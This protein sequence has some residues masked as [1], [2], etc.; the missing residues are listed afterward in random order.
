[1][2]KLIVD[3]SQL[4]NTK[5]ESYSHSNSI[6]N[7]LSSFTLT[8]FNHINTQP[9]IITIILYNKGV[10]LWIDYGTLPVFF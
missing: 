1:M 6:V 3:K 7:L 5:E 10:L 9:T 8:N 2:N 4:K